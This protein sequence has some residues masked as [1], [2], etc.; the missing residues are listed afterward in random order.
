[1]VL[2]ASSPLP[3]SSYFDGSSLD[4]LGILQALSALVGLLRVDAEDL[5]G[6]LVDDVGFSFW[7]DGDARE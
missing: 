3:N 7:T 2:S 5:G 4:L 1:M 6:S